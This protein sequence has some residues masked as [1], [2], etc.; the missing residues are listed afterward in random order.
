MHEVPVAAAD[1]CRA[2]FHQDL[3]FFGVVQLNVFDYQGRLRF[4]K[5]C[6]LQ[7]GTPKYQYGFSIITGSGKHGSKSIFSPSR[8]GVIAEW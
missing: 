4:V 5:N 2:D 6:G 1:A 3:P 7:C 8:T